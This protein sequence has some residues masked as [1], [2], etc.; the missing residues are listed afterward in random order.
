MLEIEILKEGRI[1]IVGNRFS[2]EGCRSKEI[3]LI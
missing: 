2:H 1:L 3:A